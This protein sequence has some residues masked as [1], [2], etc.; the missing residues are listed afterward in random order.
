MG[1]KTKGKPR[2]KG[3]KLSARSADRYDLY[4]R[5]VNSP[6]ADV[7]FLLDTYKTLRGK[8][9]R[10]L[11]EDFC[12]TGNLAAEWLKRG[13]DF[14]AEGFD[15]DPEPMEWGKKHNFAELG[16]AASRMTWHEADARGPSNRAPDVRTAPN[17]SYWIFKE[18]AQLVDYFKK[19]CDDLADDGLFVVDVFGGPEAITEM[20]EER[21]IGRGVSY[22]WDQVEHWPGSGECVCAIHF[23]FK[24]GSEMTEAFRYEWRVWSVPELKDIMLEAGF[25][26]AHS[27]FEGTD[28]DDEDEGDGIFTLDDKGENCQAWIGYVVASK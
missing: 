5:A 16:E 1:A 7:D 3:S 21:D 8:E 9:A 26:E 24:D 25:K 20:E 6:E 4:Q 19:C 28:P 10:R 11:R 13:E 23:R 22:V 14:T 12:G 18:R 15:L 2:T 27:Y 17:F